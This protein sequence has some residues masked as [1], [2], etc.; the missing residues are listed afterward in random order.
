MKDTFFNG[1]PEYFKAQMG[2]WIADFG[3]ETED[4]KNLSV[5][6]L[7]GKLVG[8]ADGDKRQRLVGLLG[9]A[10]RFGL[11]DAKAASFLK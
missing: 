4:I 9:A 5:S 3:V 11:G 2:S 10:E 1:D 8:S 7:L 6:A